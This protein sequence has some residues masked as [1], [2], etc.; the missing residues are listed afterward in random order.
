M[1][2]TSGDMHM[3]LDLQLVYMVSRNFTQL[4][5]I[6]TTKLQVE[7]EPVYLLTI[8]MT[9]KGGAIIFCMILA[10]PP[11]PLQTPQYLAILM[12]EKGDIIFCRILAP[13]MPPR[14]DP[15]IYA[16]LRNWGPW[17]IYYLG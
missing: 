16:K 7:R 17:T 1:E 12:T 6:N 11:P 15:Y 8:L 14:W 3:L 13:P 5:N 9:E 4:L 10:P 2:N